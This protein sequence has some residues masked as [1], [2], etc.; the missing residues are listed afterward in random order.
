ML[1]GLCIALLTWIVPRIPHHQLK[2][3]MSIGVY[4]VISWVGYGVFKTYYWK[5]GFVPYSYLYNPS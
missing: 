3:V 1:I 2:V 5:T 4:A